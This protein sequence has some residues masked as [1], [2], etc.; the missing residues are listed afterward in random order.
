MSRGEQLKKNSGRNIK[1]KPAF[2]V[3]AP[4]SKVALAPILEKL[5]E[6]S[7][8]YLEKQNLELVSLECPLEGGRR[9]IRF[10]ID[11]LA[12]PDKGS[13]VTVGE[14][15]VLSRQLARL[16][17]EIYPEDGSE[18]VLEVSSP[19]LDRALF[20]ENDFIR[21]SGSLVRM[22]ISLGVF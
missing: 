12:K 1:S 8:S 10:T 16:L 9:V 15:A 3:K 14:C 17:E 18:Y 4:I 2:S 21:F 5:T 11:H 13:S 19:G 7:V 20:N 6:L 22:K